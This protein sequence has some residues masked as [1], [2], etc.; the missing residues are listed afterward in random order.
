MAEQ[1]RAQGCGVEQ[2]SKIYAEKLTFAP[3]ACDMGALR[4]A[5]SRIF[6]KACCASCVC[7]MTERATFCLK[8]PSS[9]AIPA[10]ASMVKRTLLFLPLYHFFLIKSEKKR[11]FFARFCG[12]FVFFEVTAA[13]LVQF[14]DQG[15]TFCAAVAFELVFK[16]DLKGSFMGLNDIEGIL[17]QRLYF[18]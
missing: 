14:L 4:E 2:F 3:R 12:F 7:L 17:V 5:S 9:A 13:S 15:V 11:L 16:D 8:I 6:T 18:F 10:G 1:P